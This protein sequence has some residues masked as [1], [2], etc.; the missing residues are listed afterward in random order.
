MHYTKTIYVN[1]FYNVGM[2]LE[3]TVPI[4]AFNP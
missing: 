2:D 4:K 3:Y 1:G